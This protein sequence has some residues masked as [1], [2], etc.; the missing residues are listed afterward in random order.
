MFE[1]A[2][3]RWPLVR[4]LLA[5]LLLYF[6]FLALGLSLSESN[7]GAAWR[8]AAVLLPMLPA[9]WLIVGLGKAI[10]KLDELGRKVILDSLGLSFGFTLA[11]LL[12]L[13][14][15]AVAGLELPAITFMLLALFMMLVVLVSK[16]ALSR[17]YE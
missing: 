2:K 13:G 8:Y 9:A 10:G 15:L 6:G 17:R 4:P 5:P 1:R 7:P 3:E 14:L 11:L 12:T 16:L